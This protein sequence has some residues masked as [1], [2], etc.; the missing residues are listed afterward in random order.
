MDCLDFG[1]K[2]E[3]KGKRDL[4]DG[5]M[6]E[7]RNEEDGEDDEGTTGLHFEW[8]ATELSFCSSL[9]QSHSS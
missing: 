3:R 2:C 7:D 8:S 9:S 1:V 6:G 5:S 4:N